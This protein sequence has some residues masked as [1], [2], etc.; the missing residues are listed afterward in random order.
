[1]ITLS[2]YIAVDEKDERS[3]YALLL[4][5]G[6][7]C[8]G[9]EG[10]VPEG[11]TAVEQ[12]QRV[13]ANFPTYVTIS[14]N[15]RSESD[16]FLANCGEPNTDSHEVD[17]TQVNL[18]GDSQE[19][20]VEDKDP[21]DGVKSEDFEVDPSDNNRF[22]YNVSLNQMAGLHRWIGEMSKNNADTTTKQYSYT[23]QEILDLESNKI[24]EKK[25]NNFGEIQRRHDARVARFNTEQLAAYHKAVQHLLNPRSEQMIM[26]LSGEGGTGKSEILHAVTEYTRLLK[27]KTV[28]SWGAV[29]KTA[30]TGAAAYNI[31]GSTW[32]SALGSNSMYPF[33]TQTEVPLRTQTN[34]QKCGRGLSL[35]ILDEL[36]LSSSEA[37]FEISEKLKIATGVVTKPFG[38]VHVILSGDFYQMMPVNGS[39]VALPHVSMGC[40]RPNEA[41]LGRALY[42]KGMT[43][44]HLLTINCR[45]MS[46]N[47]VLTP[48]ADLNKKLRRGNVTWGDLEQVNAERICDT[49]PIAMQNA[50][51]NA[52]WITSTHDEIAKI[53]QAYLQEQLRK[54]KKL[55]HIIADHRVKKIGAA[56]P[57]QAIRDRLYAIGGDRK[58]QRGNLMLAHL[59]MAVG[60]RV[61]VTRNLAVEMGLYNGAM[62]TVYGFAYKGTGAPCSIDRRA[63]SDLTDPQREMPI[64]L[65][66]MD[67]DEESFPYSCDRNV[68]RLV[69]FLPIDGGTVMQNYTRWQVPILPAHA[70]TAQSV[71]GLTAHDGVVIDTGSQFF[72]GDYVAFSRAKDLEQVWLLQPANP[73]HFKT[74]A[75]YRTGINKEYDRLIKKFPQVNAGVS[76]C[77]SQKKIV[78]C[79]TTKVQ[80]TAVRTVRSSGAKGA[81]NKVNRTEAC[82][83]IVATE[84][85]NDHCH[86]DNNMQEMDR[87]QY[88]DRQF[89]GA[90]RR[91][92]VALE[93]L[94][95][96]RRHGQEEKVANRT[97]TCINVA[98]GNWVEKI[99]ATPTRSV[100]L[101][102]GDRHVLAVE[103]DHGVQIANSLKYLG[104]RARTYND[105]DITETNRCLMMTLGS[106]TGINPYILNTQFRKAAQERL[107]Q[108]VRKEVTDHPQQHH[109]NEVEVLQRMLVYDSMLDA[110]MFAYIALPA[111]ANYKINVVIHQINGQCTLEQY[112]PPGGINDQTKHITMYLRYAHFVELRPTEGLENL[113]DTFNDARNAGIYVGSNFERVQGGCN[114]NV[115]ARSASSSRETNVQ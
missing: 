33:T 13:K 92:M 101:Q 107:T 19:R 41:A 103:Q 39:S 20:V 42:E 104:Y 7:W 15:K 98:T 24:V 30:P 11:S 44:F 28:G 6:D 27:G 21:Y 62:G 26:F 75:T 14:L 67:G 87:E 63:L 93:Q 74:H 8:D 82:K 5:Y 95:S 102:I 38:G 48:L 49:I 65:V 17:Y 54:K 99:R 46:N 64:I 69:P 29:L 31:R 108:Y 9:E 45:A 60:T 70:R 22:R 114:G 2:P 47:G 94:L 35:F 112:T 84:A 50:H 81:C 86:T 73:L 85:R 57:T 68:P 91:R 115:V 110:Q 105:S 106:L 12:L 78:K 10:L 58:G 51:P 79:D 97:V 40:S 1:V 52:V 32:Q 37:L 25:V 90:W 55:V 71:Q 77:A 53:N 80:R 100:T 18:F 96:D 23:D 66:Q 88:H 56:V 16:G 4:L 76:E 34:L 111:L 72:A 3:A 61:R 59:E 113:L 89:A 36:S 43:D 109:L 83:N